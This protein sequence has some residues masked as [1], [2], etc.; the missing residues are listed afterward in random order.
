M[1]KSRKNLATLIVVA[2]LAAASVAHADGPKTSKK[3]FWVTVYYACWSQ[4]NG[5]LLPSEIDFS[6]ITHLIHFAVEPL[7][8]G[9]IDTN[10][11]AD[12]V[13]PEQSAAVITA[14]HAAK[15][16]VLLCVGGYKG[17]D[18]FHAAV[19]DP[20]AR[21]ALEANLVK[22]VV[23]RGYDGLD[24]D[25]EPL[26][27][28]DIPSFELF[29]HEI[30]AQLTAANPG[31]MMTAAAGQQPAEYAKLE[32]LF[33]QINLMTYD[34]SGRWIGPRTWFNSCL[35][36]NGDVKLRPGVP[37]PS[38]TARLQRFLDGGVPASKLS[39]G[40]AFYGF[41]W[42][43][44]SG[45]ALE[46]APGAAAPTTMAYSKIMDQYFSTTRYQWSNQAVAP[47]LSIDAEDPAQRMF[48]SYDDERL[49]AEKVRFAQERGLGGIMV[50][51]LGQ[52]YRRNKPAGE[53]NPLLTSLKQALSSTPQKSASQPL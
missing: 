51:E 14:A 4:N 8:D 23:D 29:V 6:A 7:A 33:D 1:S 5:T 39:I 32:G 19:A 27:T 12:Y 31:L 42:K 35:S 50:W 2:L 13:T 9:S 52:G 11:K 3:P 15:R 38:V 48:I 16:K 47:Y 36:D 24:V 10:T 45:P 34:L 22:L 26:N 25:Y 49:I 20:A 53:R 37:Y 30:R 46:T 17:G 44:A 28:V 40:T 18:G 21:A 41:I 43:G